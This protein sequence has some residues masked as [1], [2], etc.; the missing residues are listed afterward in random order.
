M[1]F[2]GNNQEKFYINSAVQNIKAGNKYNIHKASV[3]F[4]EEWMLFWYQSFQQFT[5]Y[6]QTYYELKGSV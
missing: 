6:T 4:S 3:T 5:M 2:N 1:N